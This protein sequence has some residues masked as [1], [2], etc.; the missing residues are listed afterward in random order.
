MR[1]KGIGDDAIGGRL[2][3]FASIF[4]PTSRRGARIAPPQWSGKALVQ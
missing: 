3:E 1:N 2:E 4:R